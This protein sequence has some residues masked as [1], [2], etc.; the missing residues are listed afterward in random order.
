MEEEQQLG[1]VP[2]HSEQA[3]QALLASVLMS[4]RALSETMELVAPDDFYRLRNQAIFSAILELN[5]R[6]H[7]VR[8]GDTFTGLQ[9]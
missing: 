5:D 7:P 8:I 6:E 2:P 1:R 3:E 4:T 9:P